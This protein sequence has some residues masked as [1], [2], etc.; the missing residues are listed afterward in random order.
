M[1]SPSPRSYN[2]AAVLF[3]MCVMPAFGAA[4]YTP[5]LVLERNLFVRERQDGL[6]Y[7]ITYLLSKMFD[8]LLIAALAS[9]PMTAF[10]FYGVRLQGQVRRCWTGWQGRGAAP[11]VG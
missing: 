8:E 7:P 5:A 1:P 9:A 3:M 4:A 10:V 2:I 6:Y 11:R